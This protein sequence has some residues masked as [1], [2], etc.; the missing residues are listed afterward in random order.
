[1]DD[2]G[3]AYLLIFL[4][5]AVVYFTKIAGAELMSLFEMTARLEAVLRAMATSVLLA[6]VVAA[7]AAGASREGVSVAIAA[8][9]M[10]VSGNALFAISSGVLTAA[11]FTALGG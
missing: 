7:V 6:I 9:A 4:I 8:I 2:N 1:M 5:S 3:Y 10:L 11:L